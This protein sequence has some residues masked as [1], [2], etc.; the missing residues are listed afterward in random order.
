MSQDVVE[1][2]FRFVECIN[3]QEVERLAEMMTEEHR[4]EDPSC[5]TYVGRGSMEE[6][7]TDYFQMCPDYTIHVSDFHQQGNR[8]FLMGQTTGSHLDLPWREEFRDKVIGIA[9]IQGQQ[10]SLWKIIADTRDARRAYGIPLLDR[11]DRR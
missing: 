11:E 10:L 4:F 1:T 9:D 8:V 2:A 7:W 5:D 6:G 3:R